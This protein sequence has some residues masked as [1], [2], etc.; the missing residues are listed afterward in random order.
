LGHALGQTPDVS[1][2]DFCFPDSIVP[3]LTDMDETSHSNIRLSV[4]TPMYNEE[5]T[6]RDCA[7]K[8][9][10]ALR[11]FDGM[12]ELILVN[13]GSTDNTL[14]IISE[15]TREDERIR[16]V[17]YKKNR[18]RGYALRQGFANCRGQYV[19][20]VESDLNYGTDIIFQLYKELFDTDTDLVI[21]SPYTKEG[22]VE[23]VPFRR[24]FMS[25]LGNKI[26]QMAV[27]A[28]ITTLSG[29]TR[30]YKGD[31]IRSLPLEEGGKEIHL[32][33]VSKACMLGCQFNEIP[34][35]L[36]WEPSQ[37]EKPQRKSKFKM[38]KLVRSHLLFGFNEAPILLFGSIGA[39]VLLAGLILGLYLSFLHFLKGD[40]IGDRVVLIMTTIFL[41]FSGLS[42][43]LFCFLAYQIRDLRKEAFKSRYEMLQGQ[44][45]P[46]D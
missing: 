12:W 41:I 3:E 23:N 42:T 16:I 20:T 1:I 7:A 14:N 31:F 36:R 13:D 27:S 21:A 15:L 22:R 2:G 10:E 35:T 11:S 32:E 9:I 5:L 4:I 28:D 39:V 40:V 38:A 37:R 19:I 6:I 18:G 44:A 8:L 26:L 46:G 17:S 25:R 30:G 45:K 43:F 33:I 24:A 34:A 29:M